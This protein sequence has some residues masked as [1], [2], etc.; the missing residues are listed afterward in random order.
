[1]A[2]EEI[3][4][5]ECNEKCEGCYYFQEGSL[6]CNYP[7]KERKIGFNFGIDIGTHECTA[8]GNK[9]YKPKVRL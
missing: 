7:F 5:N 8:Y 6:F 2:K 4:I 1:M 3:E 9:F